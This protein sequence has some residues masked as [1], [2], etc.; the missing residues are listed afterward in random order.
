SVRDPGDA[1]RSAKARARD[2]QRTFFRGFFSGGPMGN[3]GYPLRG[4]GPYADVPFLS[5]EIERQRVGRGCVGGAQTCLSPTGGFTLW[6]ASTELRY[7][8]AGPLSL[9]AF[10]DASDVSPHAWHLRW[11]HLHLSCGG[12]VRYDTPVGPL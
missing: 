4:I 1:T 5:P 7:D 6:E 3:R 8:V 11:T 2:Y 10:C 9:A 12:G